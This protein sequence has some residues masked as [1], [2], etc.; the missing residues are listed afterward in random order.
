VKT[1]LNTQLACPFFRQNKLSKSGNVII[2]RAVL[3]IK[4]NLYPRIG[5]KSPEGK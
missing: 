5:H 2:F 1:F 4:G 3:K